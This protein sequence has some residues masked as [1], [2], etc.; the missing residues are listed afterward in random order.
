MGEGGWPS[1]ER[2]PYWPSDVYIEVPGRREGQSG[3][4]PGYSRFARLV[5]LFIDDLSDRDRVSGRV[6]GRIS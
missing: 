6:S 2:G 5:F 4:A 1:Q 3:H